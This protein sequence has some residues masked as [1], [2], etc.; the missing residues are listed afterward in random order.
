MDVYNDIVLTHYCW[1]IYFVG[2]M[3]KLSYFWMK[4][5][6]MFTIVLAPLFF[7]QYKDVVMTVYCPLPTKQYVSVSTPVH[8]MLTKDIGKCLNSDLSDRL[9]NWSE[10]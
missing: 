7:Q 1:I 6:Y 4:L 8:T 5:L 2:R 9:L 10:D 3:Q